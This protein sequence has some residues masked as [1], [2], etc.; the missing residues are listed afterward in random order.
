M[1]NSERGLFEKR[2]ILGS[3]TAKGEEAEAMVIEINFAADETPLPPATD[4]EGFA[5][6]K[7]PSV[8]GQASD[9]NEGALRGALKVERPALRKGA[10]GRRGLWTTG[11]P[12]AQ[13]ANETPGMASKFGQIAM[14]KSVPDFLLPAAVEVLDHPLEPCLV[15]RNENRDDPETQAQTHDATEDVAVLVR[16]LKTGVVVELDI[17]GKAVCA[18]MPDH[19]RNRD[20]GRK[21]GS[22]GPGAGQASVQGTCGEHV[23]Q[24]TVL[25][26]QV[27]DDVEAVQL[28]PM[29]GNLRQIP[30]AGR[31]GA[32][33]ATAAVQ[34]PASFENAADGP[35]RGTSPGA[36]LPEL[37]MDGL[38]AVLAQVAVVRERTAHLQDEGFPLRRSPLRGVRARRPVG[39]IR[40]VQTA[41]LGAVDPPH[42]GGVVHVELSSH[43]A[44]RSPMTHGAYHGFAL[45]FLRAF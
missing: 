17:G 13:R 35:R 1:V 37:P 42:H 12:A 18:P 39:Q 3:A 36:A 16:S 22:G 14:M 24:G 25:E 26:P 20:G 19:A 44:N 15:G 7:G 9:V 2:L 28:G 6:E 31:C 34:R 5:E 11:A 21:R 32:A 41:A 40:P 43:G 29:G 23:Q 45:P 8:L 30:S 10:A 33:G 38:G 27:L 4:K